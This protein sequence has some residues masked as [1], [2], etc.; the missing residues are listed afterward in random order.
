MQLVPLEMAM[1][2]LRLI[3]GDDSP[4]DHEDRSEVE[5]RLKH[6]T[7][8]VLDYIKD[9]DN[10]N[11]WTE[12]TAPGAVQASILIVLSDLWEHRAGSS[13]DDVFISVAVERLL[14]RYRD[15]TLA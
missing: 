14:H 10:E 7:E 1:R 12:E 8:I 5:F 6:A 15:P 4:E 2:Q 13:S 9:R 11:G 3:A